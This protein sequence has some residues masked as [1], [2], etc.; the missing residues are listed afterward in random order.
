MVAV[1][2]PFGFHWVPTFITGLFLAFTYSHFASRSH[3][4]AIAA[5]SAFHA[6]IKLVGS[7]VLLPQLKG[8]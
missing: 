7:V 2:P 8:S 1:H 4:V 6:S 5:T 3:G